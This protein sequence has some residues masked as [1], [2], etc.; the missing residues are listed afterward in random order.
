MLVLIVVS[1][2]TLGAYTFS[3]SMLSENEATN[4]YGRQAQSRAFADSGIE[5]TAALLSAPESAEDENYYHN[6]DRFQAVLMRSAE[7]A[8]GRG[9]F[10]CVAP[11]ET[12][13]SSAAI[14][15]GLIDESGRININE[16][17]S[18]EL[19]DTQARDMLMYL[20]DMT[21]EAADAI[22]DWIDEDGTMREFGSETDYYETLATPY[23][24]RNGKFE[25]LEELLKVAGVTPDLLYGEDVNRNGLLDPNENDGDASLP[26]DN[27]DGILN[28]GWVSY[29]TIDSTEI[30]LRADGSDR[31]YLNN[32]VLTDLFDTLAEEFD[33]D[34]AMFV[35]AFRLFGPVADPTDTTTATDIGAMVA[36]AQAA[37]NSNNSSA[38]M[39]QGINNLGQA[40]AGAM[41]GDVT[42]L[43]LDLSGGAQFEIRSIYELI[44]ATIESQVDGK[45]QTLTSPWPNDDS[46]TAY[47]P[48]LMDMLTVVN[49]SEIRG[50]INVNQARLETLYGIPGVTADIAD[51][52]VGASMISDDGTPL[53]DQ[54]GLRSTTGWLVSEG[55][56]DLPKMVELDRYL[57]SRGHVFRTQIVGYFEEGGG[58]TRLE[59]VIDATQ[60]PARIRSVSDLTEL[61]R[62]YSTNLLSGIPVEKE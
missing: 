13:P 21:E 62:G 18:F 60:S 44:G 6:P 15:F 41:E 53:T 11:V 10:A 12:D 23:P 40:L 7:A 29:L 26:L 47:L 56:V 34:T 31:I 57:N 14:R 27:A 42:R 2:L 55:I 48:E 35:V 5:L 1:I 22:L 3:E 36:G 54:I 46:L 24:A 51:A 45:P 9:L 38:A 39:A 37:P 4:M 19:D 17:L 8:R 59:A 20:P 52:I 28:P 30:N 16:I 50:R 25:S 58:Y 33:E 49:A 32:G 43:G 61:G